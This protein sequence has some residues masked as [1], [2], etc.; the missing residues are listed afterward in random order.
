MSYTT[1][2]GYTKCECCDM[3]MRKNSYNAHTKTK[4]HIINHDKFIKFQELK[5][6]LGIL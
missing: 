1:F 4:G 3:R 2:E 5:K 6:K